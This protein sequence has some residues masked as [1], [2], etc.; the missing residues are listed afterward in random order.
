VAGDPVRHGPRFEPRLSH[1]GVI[2]VGSDDDNV[3]ALNASTGVLLWSYPV[4][5]VS[6]PAVANGVV[7]VGS[8]DD[9]IYALNA[10]TG[11]VLWSDTTGNDV[12][13]SPAVANGVVY[14]SSDD[15]NVYAF[16]VGVVLGPNRPNPTSLHPN[17][18]LKASA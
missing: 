16:S 15:T 2:Y 7:Y 4:F 8:P 9:K 10:S 3:Y 13:S 1:N 18:G 11:A 12:T 14:V 6:S 17:L 5:V